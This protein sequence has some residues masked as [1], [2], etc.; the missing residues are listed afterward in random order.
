MKQEIKERVERIRNGEVPEE[1]RKTKVGIIPDD[2]KI[3]H[4]EDITKKKGLIRGPFGGSLKKEIFVT[5]GFKVYEQRNAIYKSVKLGEY[6]ID[7]K[8]FEELKRFEIRKDDFI[9]SCSGTIGRIFRLPENSPIGVINQAL[10]KITIDF[11]LVNL[12]FFQQYFEYDKFQHL[13]IDN[14]QGGAMS[15]LVG[16]DLF[17]KTPFPLLGI[18]EQKKIAEILSIWGTAIE[19]KEKLIEEKMEFKEGTMQNIIFA[20]MNDASSWKF[21]KFKEIFKII[22]RPIDKHPEEEYKRLTVKRRLGGVQLRDTKK[23]KEILV[24]SQHIV[25]EGDFVISNRQVFH[26]AIGVVQ[27][28]LEN[29]IVSTDYSILRCNEGFDMEFLFYCMYSPQFKKTII[30]RTQ[31]VTEEKFV[32]LFNEWYKTLGL[33][34]PSIDEQKSTVSVLN[35]LNENI[36]ILTNEVAQL[37]EQKRG[38]MQLL[39]TGIVRVEVN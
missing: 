7:G 15:N 31:G 19:L 21:A 11:D 17:R 18:E 38:L 33:H 30:K 36:Q 26:G 12:D 29:A 35:N 37:K 10:L 1:Y 25:K 13:I 20:Q 23:G 34:I 27:K 9:I 24:D 4:L 8:K 16:M 39:L 22:K 28:K 32:F 6:F 2:W 5:N 3:V 14:T